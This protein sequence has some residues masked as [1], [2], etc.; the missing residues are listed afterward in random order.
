MRKTANQPIVFVSALLV[1]TVFSFKAHSQKLPPIKSAIDRE[2]GE[3]REIKVS[4][5]GQNAPIKATAQLRLG[6]QA[7]GDGLL[8]LKNV[9][10]KPV[11]AFKGAWKIHISDGSILTDGWHYGGA[12][13]VV[14]G[15]LILGEHVTLPVTGPPNLT[16]KPP[17]RIVKISIW[18]TGVVF[19]DLTR[20]G[21]DAGEVYHRLERDVE[22]MRQV[23]E[24]LL[25]ACQKSSPQEFG[26]Q[27][28]I[29]RG[30]SL[31][32]DM[33]YRMLFQHYLLDDAKLM[34]HDAMQRLE[35]LLPKLKVMNTP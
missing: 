22:E 23:A 33:K 5:S 3:T 30:N 26:A 4:N 7:Y 11:L 32:P 12:S 35:T 18:I 25:A 16:V 17:H 24:R 6:Q 1:A 8:Q 27:L 28:A 13:S 19:N 9:S 14:K 10:A 29:E 20:W 2:S 31:L 34:R 15:G 21:D